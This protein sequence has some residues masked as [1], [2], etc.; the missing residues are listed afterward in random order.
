M[1]PPSGGTRVQ[2]VQRAR[3]LYSLDSLDYFENLLDLVRLARVAK[4]DWVQ[5]KE[6]KQR[7]LLGIVLGFLILVGVW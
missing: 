4:E 1:G 3:F 5:K 2:M 6:R 7:R